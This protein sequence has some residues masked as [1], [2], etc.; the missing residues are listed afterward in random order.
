MDSAVSLHAEKLTNQCLAAYREDPL[1]VQ[2]HANIERATA[3]GGYGRRQLYELVQNAADAQIREDAGH[4]HVILTEDTLYCANEGDPFTKEGVEAVMHSHIS[5]KRGQEIGRFGLGFKSVLEISKRPRIYSRSGSF[6]FDAEVAALK[7]KDAV[8]V[9]DRTPVLRTAFAVDPA[10]GTDRNPVLQEL[11]Q[12][13]TTII[14]LPIDALETE[15]IREDFKNFPASF[16][17]FSPH[18][19][20]LII[21]DRSSN[22]IREVTVS[23]ESGDVLV[24]TDGA[25]STEWKVFHTIHFPSNE[26]KK[27]GGELA[28]RDSL[29]LAWAVP[30]RTSRSQ[31]GRFWAFFPTESYTTLSGVLNAPWKTNEDRQNLLPG[32]FNDE[33]LEAAANLIAT[34]IGSL[35]NADDPCRYLDLLPARGKEAPNWADERLS[36]LT[37]QAVSKVPCIPDQNGTLRRPAELRIHPPKLPQGAIEAWGAY[38]G[39]PNDWVHFSVDR[40]E[41]RRSR[42]ERL[43]S[44][45]LRSNVTV[46]TWLTALVAD[47]SVPSSAAAIVAA[48]AIAAVSSMLLPFIQLS[49]IVMTE[50]EEWVKPDPERLYYRLGGEYGDSKLSLV[51][52]DVVSDERVPNA[53]TQIQI[54]ELDATSELRDMLGKISH[55]NADWAQLWAVARRCPTDDAVD[56]LGR[57]TDD[58]IGTRLRVRTMADKFVDFDEVLLPG[59]IVTSE[60][61]DAAATVDTQFH[62]SE[63][64]LLR[65]LGVLDWPSVKPA[66]HDATMWYSRYEQVYRRTFDKMVALYPS[67][68]QARMINFQKEPIVQPLGVIFSL[69]PESNAAFT[70]A[71]LAV[72]VNC[73]PWKLR[74]DTKAENYPIINAPPPHLWVLRDHGYLKTSQGVKPVKECVG[75]VLRHLSAWLPVAECSQTEAEQLNLAS[76][77]EAL[78]TAQWQDACLEAAFRPTPDDGVLFAEACSYIPP[79]AKLV[80]SRIAISIADIPKDTPLL[81]PR[82]IIVTADTATSKLLDRLQVPYYVVPDPLKAKLLVEKW[83]FAESDDRIVS[84]VNASPSSGADI[85]LCDRFPALVDYLS[86]SD[87]ELLLSPCTDIEKIWS[88]DTSHV[89]RSLQVLREPSQIR[90]LDSLSDPDL[91]RALSDELELS[92]DSDDITA[93]LDRRQ[94]DE[95]RRRIASAFEAETTGARLAALLSREALKLRIPRGI[96]KSMEVDSLSDEMLGEIAGAA[97]GVEILQMLKEDLSVGGLEIPQQWAGGYFTRRF[98]TTLG[99]EREYAGFRRAD[100]EPAMDIDGPPDLPP[101]HDFQAVIVQRIQGLVQGTGR[102]RGLISLPT[103]AGKTRVATEALVRALRDGALD[104][105]ILWVAQSDELC[106][107]AVQTWSDIW[108]GVGTRKRLRINRLWASNEAD[109]VEDGPQVVVATIDKLQNCINSREYEWL[110]Q[111]ACV[112]IDEAHSSITKEYTALLVWQGLTRS[113]DRAPLIGL[114][115]TP[116][117]GGLE[118]TQ[119]LAS[120]YAMNR[121][122][123]GVLGDSPYATLQQMGVLAEVDHELLEGTEFDLDAAELQQLKQMNSL[124]QSV[125]N[126]IGS[127]A[128]RNDNLLRSMLHHPSDWPMLLFAVSVDHAHTMAALLTLN[129]IPAAAV[130]GATDPGA[131]RHY[132]EQFRKGKLRVLTNYGVLTAGFDAPAVRAVYIA[133]PTFSPV[134]YQQMIGRGLRGPKNGGK[135]RCLI[136]NVLDTFTQF[137][138]ELA[139]RDFEYLWTPTEAPA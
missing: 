23:P 31:R 48:G 28:D 87:R 37:Y 44:Y 11:M 40:S 68:P 57:F 18:V 14:E 127:D 2:E 30:V 73:S 17:L 90:F 138:R 8:A 10:A 114:T 70:K 134:L 111:A 67:R 126:R 21:E 77:P 112:V 74:H 81:A 1:L 20:S 104:G 107:Q 121:L 47:A 96:S 52:P 124:P 12:W 58:V 75:P 135:A 95:D 4:I 49:P 65:A 117:R 19:G 122:D 59:Q 79:P 94:N 61:L 83:G 3:Q 103:G 54:R 80:Y 56:L 88:T 64:P 101:L 76:A 34:N 39:R 50:T 71:C 116:F 38:P 128:D 45:N 97:Y 5:Q 133:R 60:G 22:L 105:P 43:L 42:V 139:F 15:W 35:M 89:S 93:I 27:D 25:E 113:V 137:G 110:S 9:A 108:R 106:E 24:L 123:D 130:S 85:P 53:L 119:R 86:P 98:V 118:E 55:Y 129:G 72:G 63:L 69:R 32:P 91:L 16:I 7:I 62:A 6:G 92:L 120:R 41:N 84:T 66:D 132:I 78:T 136:V 33:L 131:R 82:E 51:H 29:P 36:D 99:F 109:F 26:A 13:A 102:R 115:A 46:G 125:S 100:R